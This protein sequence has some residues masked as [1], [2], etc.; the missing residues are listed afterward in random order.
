MTEPASL[1]TERR[2]DDVVVSLRGELDVFN[3]AD[4]TAQI[5][6]AVPSDAHGAVIDLS[7]V[8]FLDSTAIR[9]LFSLAARLSERRQR[10][11]VV[12]PEGSSVLRTL[13]LVEFTRAAPMHDTLQ[14]ALTQ[15]DAGRGGD[16]G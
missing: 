5:E 7:D 9:K 10:V 14:D 2:G 11:H 4:M 6:A 13:Q 16:P 15:L 8:G 1:H 12:S 3:A